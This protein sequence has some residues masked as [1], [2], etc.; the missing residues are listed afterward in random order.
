MT[1]LLPPM[2]ECPMDFYQGTKLVTVAHLYLEIKRF[3]KV[4]WLW[5]NGITTYWGGVPNGSQL[6]EVYLLSKF[7]PSSFSMTGDTQIFK[8]VILLTLSSLK[9]IV[10]LAKLKLTLLV[11]IYY[12][13]QVKVILLSLGMMGSHKNQSQPSLFDKKFKN[14]A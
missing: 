11:H 14:Q 10:T 5:G 1:L 6:N 4:T 2:E 12:F 3:V 7:H 8:L 13:G 9:L